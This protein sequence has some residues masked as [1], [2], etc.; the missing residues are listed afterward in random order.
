MFILYSI[1][2]ETGVQFDLQD[3]GS[4]MGFGTLLYYPYLGSVQDELSFPCLLCVCVLERGK[5]GGPG[6][7]R[8]PK[9]QTGAPKVKAP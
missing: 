8:A 7:L 4:K 5:E 9:V 3:E 6:A 1:Y 2:M